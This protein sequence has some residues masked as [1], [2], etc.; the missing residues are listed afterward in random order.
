[1]KD[2]KPL[3]ELL[4]KATKEWQRTKAPATVQTTPDSA[5]SFIATLRKEWPVA[6]IRKEENR[7]G[8]TVSLYADDDVTPDDMATA[9]SRL[10]VAFPRKE[11]AF[12]NLLAERIMCHRFTRA[13]LAEA[14]NKAIDGCTFQNLQIADIIKYDRRLR[15]YA[16]GEVADMWADGVAKSDDFEKRT[17]GDKRYWVRKCDLDDGLPF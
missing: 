6:D 17:I 5:P 9:L 3:N 1:M 13:R 12:F 16:Y 11:D 8:V 15:Y 4:P 14:V 2:M 7:G 10:R